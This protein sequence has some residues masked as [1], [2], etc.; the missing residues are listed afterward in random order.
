MS[1]ALDSAKN[2]VDSGKISK[3]AFEKMASDRDKILKSAG[4]TD[5]FT[6]KNL[7]TAAVAAGIIPIISAGAH[8]GLSGL[9]SMLEAHRLSKSKD[10]M[11][12]VE[13]DLAEIPKEQIDKA[14]SFLSHFA[15][16][17]AKNPIAAANFVKNLTLMPAMGDAGVVKGLVDIE[18]GGPEGGDFF[19]HFLKGYSENVGRTTADTLEAHLMSGD[20]ISKLQDFRSKP[21]D[22]Q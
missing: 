7:G 16:S 5:M 11:I 10:Q 21:K 6:A 15:P 18:R 1:K 20:A 14:F 9:N 12:D 19:S 22:A 4:L 3:E 2:L 17:V 8:F 13:P